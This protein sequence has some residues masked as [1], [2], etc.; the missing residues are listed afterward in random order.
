MRPFRALHHAVTAASGGLHRAIRPARLLLAAKAA[1]AVTIAWSIAPLVPGSADDYPYYAPLG[2]L[3]SMYP[4]LM[5]SLRSGVQTLLGL[6]VGIGLSV[7]IVLTI[8]PSVWTIGLAVGLGV[9]LS[10]TGWFGSGSEYLPIAALFVLLL[11]RGDPDGY[12]LGYVTQTALG[13]AVGLVINLVIPP[14]PLV[15]QAEGRVQHFQ[16]DLAQHLDDIADAV[17]G[18]WPPEQAGWARDSRALAETGRSLHDALAEADD[19]RRANPRV[20]LRHHDSRAVHERLALLDE[21]AHQIRDIAGCLGD[22]V[23]GRGAALPLNPSL[24]PPLS[25]ACRAVAEVVREA[26]PGSPSADTD[27]R[28]AAEDA[29]LRLRRIVA[30]ESIAAAE[31]SGP[32][33]LSAMHLERILQLTAARDADEEE[34]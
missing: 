9:L 1:V 12:S 16:R 6:A 2:A 29:V 7:V 14:A 17:A 33:V 13:I 19:S 3:I 18:S 8:G 26:D 20:W 5:G 24:V 32:G 21:V 15:A 10:G 4:T 34:P 11:G 28:R 23:L 25:G 22:T 27:A 31:V 30:T